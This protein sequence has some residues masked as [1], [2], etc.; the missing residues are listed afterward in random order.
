[1]DFSPPSRVQPLLKC[2]RQFVEE[3]LYPLEAEYLHRPFSEV[4]PILRAKRERVKELGLWLPQIPERWG[5]LG[6]SV[7]EHGLLSEVLGTTPFGHFACGCQAP[8]AGNMEIL[9]EYGTPE[10]QE[11]FLKPLLAGEMRSCFAMT[12]PDRAGSNPLQLGTTATLEGDDY[13]ISGRKWFTSS[14]DGAAFA[15]VMAISEPDAPPHERA[16]QIL[17]PTNTPGFEPVRLL[18]ILGHRGDG[19]ASHSEILLRRCRVPRGNL[20]GEPG[21]GFTIAQARLGPGRIHHCMRWIGICERSFDLL[22][23]RAASRELQPGK[24]LGQQQTVQGWIAESRAEI[25]AARLMVLQA[26]WQIDQVGARAAREQ[27]SAIKFFVAGVMTRVIDRAV[28]VHGA[29]GLTDDTVLAWFYTQERGA[30]IYDGPDEVHKAVVAREVL[31]RYGVGR[32]GD[33]A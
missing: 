2:A 18:P 8:D 9:I 33:G 12:E 31:R 32:S 11:R 17:V 30:R 23:R 19:W 10:Q 4:E 6:L 21:S 15:I 5:G 25:N 3:E 26:A 1:M 7:L 13:V 27:I 14:A 24:V 22:C 29:M 16:S 28:Q 20:L